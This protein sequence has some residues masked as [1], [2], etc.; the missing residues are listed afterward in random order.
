MSRR[1]L[2]V[3]DSADLSRLWQAYFQ[4]KGFDL[5]ICPDG[6]TAMKHLQDEGL[7]FDVVV[8]DFFLPDITGLELLHFLRVHNP[9]LPFLMITGHKDDTVSLE[10]RKAGRAE[11]FFKP[12]SLKRIEDQLNAWFPRS[13]EVPIN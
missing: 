8:S 9:N 6:A 10:V 2:L 3:E 1:I 12:A 5:T 13:N 4:M 7:S 11:I